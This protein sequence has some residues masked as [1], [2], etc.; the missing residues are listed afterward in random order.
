MELHLGMG[1]EPS[2]S[3]WVRIKGR[4]GTDDI[5]V[6]LSCRPPDQEDQ[7]HEALFRQIG[8]ALRS[9]ALVLTGDFSHTGICWKD[10][11]AGHKMSGR[12]LEC[13]NDNFIL[14]VTEEPTK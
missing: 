7:V 10:N 9:Q 5:V 11:K 12:F 4:A 8:A 3:L 2:E 14:Q 13:I 1:E 6:G